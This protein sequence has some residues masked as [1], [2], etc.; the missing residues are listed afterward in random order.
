LAQNHLRTQGRSPSHHRPNQWRTWNWLPFMTTSRIDR[1]G[2]VPRSRQ[3]FV[4]TWSPSSASTPKSL[5]GPTMTCLAYH[6]TSYL[7][8]LASILP[9]D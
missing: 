6:Q 2:S 9:S 4:L 3:S 7:I 8:G 5:H 1:S